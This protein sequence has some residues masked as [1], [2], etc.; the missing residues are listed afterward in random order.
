MYC[1]VIVDGRGSTGGEVR[2]ERWGSVR[3]PSEI[4]QDLGIA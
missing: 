3:W 2:Q 4:R 1:D